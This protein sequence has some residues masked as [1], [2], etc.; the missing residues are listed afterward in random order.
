LGSFNIPVRQTFAVP[1]IVIAAPAS[2]CFPGEPLEKNRSRHRD[3]QGVP[4][5]RRITPP[6][7]HLRDLCDFD[8]N[9][10]SNFAG[11][12]YPGPPAAVMTGR[13][14][15]G[16]ESTIVERVVTSSLPPERV[17]QLLR[18]PRIRGAHYQCVGVVPRPPSSKTRQLEFGNESGD[19]RGGT[20]DAGPAT[21]RP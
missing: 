15:K 1:P 5:T 2:R 11:D 4:G 14:S 19:V 17:Q 6:R 3:C 21:Q 9:M 12:G 8:G 18:G 10:C 20:P 13:C 7:Q 16:V